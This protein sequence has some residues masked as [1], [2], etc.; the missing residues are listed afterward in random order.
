VLIFV[1]KDQRSTKLIFHI[2]V[3]NN[4]EIC[5]VLLETKAC[6]LIILSLCR[7]LLG[8]IN[9]SVSGINATLKY[10]YNT[11]CEFLICGDINIRLSQWKQQ[12]E[13]NSL[14]T[15]YKFTHTVNIARK[16]QS[17]LSTAIDNAFVDITT[18]SSF[19]T[20]LIIN[21]LS[22]KQYCCSR[23]LKVF[24]ADSKENKLMKPSCSFSF[25]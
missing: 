18:F 7:T 14:L 11:K 1:N 8:D 24:E 5:A 12:K 17:D 25:F 3:K 2:T 9:R 23:L 15:T 6:N 21:G 20:P 4:L 10:L 22:G 13:T 16:I 19:R